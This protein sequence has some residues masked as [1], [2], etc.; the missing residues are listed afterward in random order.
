MSISWRAYGASAVLVS[1]TLALAMVLDRVAALPDY[2]ILFVPA[3]L[4]SATRWGLGPSLFT[5]AVSLL[6]YSFFFVG[7]PYSLAIE[8]VSDAIALAVFGLIAV[9]TGNLVSKIRDQANA[10][11][12][13]ERR[14]AALYELSRAVSGIDEINTLAPTLAD[15]M[16]LCLGKPVALWL[17][18]SAGSEPR[19]LASSHPSLMQEAEAEVLGL[20]RAGAPV[21]A[22][23]APSGRWGLCPLV[24][25]GG[26]IGAIVVEA[27]CLRPPA[28][29]RALTLALA[30]FAAATLLRVLLSREVERS[31]RAAEAERFRSALLNSVS[32]DLRT[33]LATITGTAT[34][35]LAAADRLSDDARRKLLETLHEEAFRLDRF[36]GNLL[37]MTRLQAGVL[38][39]RP[40]YVEVADVVGAAVRRLQGSL[41]PFK[42]EIDIAADLPLIRIDEVLTEHALLNLID[43]AAKHSPPGG[44]IRLA[45]QRAA[46][47][48]VLAVEDQGPG[49]PKDQADMIFDAF[50]RASSGDRQPAGTGLGL[51][52]CKAF[53]DA[54]G[55]RVSVGRSRL[56]GARFVLTFPFA[57]DPAP[58]AIHA[59]AAC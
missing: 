54:Q 35:L 59:A 52:I 47:G 55:G 32:H 58:Q 16:A 6:A 3:I 24:L 42:V 14:T 56:G 17:A 2:D 4:F 12:E 36:V 9:V 29:Q 15:G 19:L 27:E 41:A 50:H 10:A 44:V 46:E 40:D 28:A 5:S 30:D 39:L 1:A 53:V 31:R 38:T 33:P 13:R 45:A 51:A 37:D 43:N 48:V 26:V 20:W 57:A 22:Q 49:V 18:E 7:T 25:E 8:T 23:L 34:T 21:E 11:A